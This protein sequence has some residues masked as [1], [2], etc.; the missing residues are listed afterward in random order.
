MSEW[1]DYQRHLSWVV[2]GFLRGTP[3]ARVW[4]KRILAMCPR[5]KPF[6]LNAIVWDSIRAT[7][8]DGVMQED[9]E[10]LQALERFLAGNAQIIN[11]G[12]FSYDLR[13]EMTSHELECYTR[14]EEL[15]TFLKG[16]PF[17]DEEHAMAEYDRRC[18]EV[19]PMAMTLS[20]Q[21]S[22]SGQ[23]GDETIYHLVLRE[24]A[25]VALSINMRLSLHVAKHLTPAFEPVGA[26]GVH[27]YRRPPNLADATGS[28]EWARKALSAIAGEEWLYLS[29]QLNE[30]ALRFSLH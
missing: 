1:F 27:P 15:L 28:V 16:F 12:Y 25:V 6:T 11:R 26:V 18:A 29:W 8:G 20:T 13:P 7:L 30:H 24:V 2:R 10:Y 23:S 5:T 21:A 17:P 3:T 9:T 14:L 22:T 19:A 4:A